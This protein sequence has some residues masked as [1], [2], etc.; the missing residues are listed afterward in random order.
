MITLYCAIVDWWCK[1]YIDRTGGESSQ[2][3]VVFC[4]REIENGATCCW[5]DSW[6]NSFI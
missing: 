5:S 3:L 6:R 2:S 4:C 1:S